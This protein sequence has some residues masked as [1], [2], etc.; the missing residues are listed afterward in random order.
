MSISER[1][2]PR[3]P[4]LQWPQLG[5]MS[6]LGMIALAIVLIHVI[7]ATLMLPASSR[8]AATVLED[9][10]ASFTD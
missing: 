1:S 9:A 4:P 3:R 2:S 8:G 10:K 5:E 7:A 6:W